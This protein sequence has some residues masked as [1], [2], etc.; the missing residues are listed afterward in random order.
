MT[1]HER[2][3]DFFGLG[4]DVYRSVIEEF[5]R[6]S[7]CDGQCHFSAQMILLIAKF[8]TTLLARFTTQIS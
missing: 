8:Q 7:L 6:G 2:D 5:E 3:V 1:R 4:I